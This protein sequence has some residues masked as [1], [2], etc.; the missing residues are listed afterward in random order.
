MMNSWFEN[1]DTSNTDLFAVLTPNDPCD[2]KIMDDLL[3]TGLTRTLFWYPKSYMPHIFFTK[4]LEQCTTKWLNRKWLLPVVLPVKWVT[5]DY[6]LYIIIL[7]TNISKYNN[8]GCLSKR[9][10]MKKINHDF[11]NMSK[12]TF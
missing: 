9:S 10:I 11:Q 5:S 12:V 7:L 2:P 3:S 6:S 1:T 4:S 8:F